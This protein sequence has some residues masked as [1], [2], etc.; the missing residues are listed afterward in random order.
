MAATNEYN[1]KKLDKRLQM[2]EKLSF[3]F[4]FFFLPNICKEWRTTIQIYIF[5]LL[6]IAEGAGIGVRM[7]D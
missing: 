5:L 3:F 1:F 6:A 7:L 4:L 2:I